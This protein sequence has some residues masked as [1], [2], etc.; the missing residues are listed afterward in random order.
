MKKRFLN[1][2]LVAGVAM[3]T[4]ACKNNNENK[5]EP[6]EAQE[7]AVATEEAMTYEIDT[8]ASTIEWRGTKPT[9]EHVGTINIEDGTLMAT[10]EEITS[11]RV[12]IDMNSITVTD[13]GM[14]EKD[15]RSLEDHLKGTVEGKETDFFNVNKYPTATFEITGVTEENGQK[16]L[17][18][19]LTLKE[20]TK[21]IQFPVNTEIN[22]ETITLKS[23]TFIIDRTNW[24]VN[25]GSKSVFDNLGDK[26]ISDE[27]ELTVNV[28]ARKTN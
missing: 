7:A 26:F 13:E 3:G 15:K 12:V 27:M 8:T 9:G 20:E 4:V 17:Q 22:G 24:G 5:V 11:G 25:Y 10:T 21:N 23:E 28:T 1:F 14:E 2:V 19:N 6:G 16:V 18:G